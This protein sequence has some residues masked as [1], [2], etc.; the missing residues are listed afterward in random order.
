MSGRIRFVY[1][2]SFPY[3]GSTLFSFLIN[4]H[5]KIATV[6]E[7]T[8]PT[9]TQDPE[10][11]KCSCGQKMRQ[12]PFWMQVAEQMASR[13]FSFQC[14]S[15]DTR[16][17]LGNSFQAQRILSGSLRSSFLEDLRDRMLRFWPSQWQ[18]QQYLVS[19]RR[20]MAE[21]ILQLTNKSLFFDAS[22]SPM[23]IRH[24]T[25]QPDVDLRVV[26]LVRDV[27][28]A[29]HSKRKNQGAMD[30]RQAVKAWVR[31]NRSIERQLELLPSDKWIRLRYEDLCQDPAAT[32]NLFFHFCGMSPH[33]IPQD[34]QTLEHH[35]VGNRMRLTDV[36]QI[37]LD[38]SWRRQITPE[39]QDL[40]IRLASSMQLR[41]GY[42]RMI[43]A[44]IESGAT[45]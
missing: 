29:S 30:W 22:K 20:A 12:C 25:A 45:R 17:Q 24:L 36:G 31:E 42:P 5:P 39:E 9:A 13:G 40:A 15:F 41:Y 44:D 38:E 34:F 33:R 21:S 7:M 35:I 37:H 18:R 23:T 1:L 16:I 4:A 43:A 27:R 11:Y 19:R 14:M 26:H 8:G 10:A 2:T 32:L 6:G 28:G 3:S